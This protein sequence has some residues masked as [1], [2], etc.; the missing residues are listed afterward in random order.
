MQRRQEVGQKKHVE[1]SKKLGFPLNNRS[2]LILDQSEDVT[3]TEDQRVLIEL[4]QNRDHPVHQI[5]S[6]ALDICVHMIAEAATVEDA[7]AMARNTRQTVDDMV[8]TAVEELRESKF[9]AN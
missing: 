6:E 9:S 7:H 3:L 8:A 1:I 5:V 2:A 4:A